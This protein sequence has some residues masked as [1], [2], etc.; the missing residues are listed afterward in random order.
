MTS[1]V[2]CYTQ[3]KQTNKTFKT[4][5]KVSKVKNNQK[6]ILD[7]LSLLQDDPLYIKL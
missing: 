7:K 6:S 3:Q 2:E 5:K 4:N 1:K